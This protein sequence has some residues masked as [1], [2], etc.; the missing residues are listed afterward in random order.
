[1]LLTGIGLE[2]RPRSGVLEDD[3]R[4]HHVGEDNVLYEVDDGIGRI[5][6]HR[7][8]VLNALSPGVL[9]DLAAAFAKAG[10]D[11]AVGVVTLTG[12]GERAFS[13]GAD[14]AYLNRASPLEVRAEVTSHRR[15]LVECR[16][17]IFDSEGTLLA[18]ATGKLIQANERP[19]D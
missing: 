19:C 18:A 9:S 15:R 13:A 5:T 1:M 3:E 4:Q 17:E 11:P 16:A 8:D 6:L 2:A 14:I 7:P 10:D 12:A